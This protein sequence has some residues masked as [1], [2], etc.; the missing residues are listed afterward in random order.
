MKKL[1]FYETPIG[2]VALAE[3][4]GRITNL[5]LP[6]DEAF[7]EQY[8]VEETSLLREAAAQLTEY[9]RGKRK[10]FTLPLQPQGTDFYQKVWW[11][12]LDIPYGTTKSYGQIA[13]EA[14]NPKACRA[15]GQANNK[16]PIPI[17]IPC[18]RVIGAKGDLVGFGGGLATKTYLLELE[19]NNSK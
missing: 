3:E 13:A 10:E 8:T 7:S 12:L 6:K 2:K 1:F 17:F 9:F 15:I 16:N 14:G 11:R 19:K 4:N 5:Q 18:H